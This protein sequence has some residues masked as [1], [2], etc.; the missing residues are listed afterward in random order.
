MNSIADGSVIIQ[1]SC[2]SVPSTPPWFGEVA[3]L[4]QY[5]RKH[6]ILSTRASRVRFARRRFGHY[7]VIDFVAV[8]LGY[9]ISG[10]QTLEAFYQRLHPFAAGF[11]APFGREALPSGSTASRLLS[12]LA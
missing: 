11:M 7:E 1:T 5:L 10:E 2:Q 6:D 9:A 4:V 3:L 12:A 8:L